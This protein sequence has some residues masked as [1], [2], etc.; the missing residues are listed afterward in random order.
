[1]HNGM[2]KL[3]LIKVAYCNL[4]ASH[5]SRSTRFFLLNVSDLTI[6]AVLSYFTI[7]STYIY[8]QVNC[9]T[10]RQSHQFFI[11]RLFKLPHVSAF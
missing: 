4:F 3:K 10:F 5:F 8:Q 11:R 9:K 1:M 7:F 6:F 2:Y